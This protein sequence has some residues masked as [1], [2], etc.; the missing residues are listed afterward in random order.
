V[1]PE[2]L[3]RVLAS[4]RVR[5]WVPECG[6]GEPVYALAMRFAAGSGAIPLRCVLFGTARERSLIA[7]AR[8]AVYPAV[9][10]EARAPL[11]W[12]QHFFLKVDDQCHVRG[13]IRAACAFGCLDLACDPPLSRLHLIDASGVVAGSDCETW[14]WLCKSFHFAL[15]PDGLLLLGPRQEAVQLPGFE[16]LDTASGLYRRAPQGPRSWLP[17]SVSSLPP[18]MKHGQDPEPHTPTAAAMFAQSSRL[19]HAT[20]GRS[21]SHAAATGLEAIEA[22]TLVVTTLGVGLV[23]FD[24]LRR[25]RTVNRV[26][27]D[28]FEVDASDVVQKPMDR[29]FPEAWGPALEEMQVALVSSRSTH[30]ERRPSTARGARQRLT[31]EC[32][33]G[34]LRSF[35]VEARCIDDSPLVLLVFEETT[36]PGRA[37]RDDAENEAVVQRRAVDGAA[38]L[39]PREGE[40]LGLIAEGGSTKSIAERLGI[41]PSTVETYRRQIMDK[42][43]L[44]TIAELTKYAVRAGLT[45]P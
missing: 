35:W 36:N 21:S 30:G 6:S 2:L 33:D 29:V 31:R 9:A 23:I 43:E 39:S 26:F 3:G 32:S 25:V 4:D 38:P 15:R 5:I 44:R 24:E 17:S 40:V 13:D 19:F 42:L 8:A 27:C 20:R 16:L 7:A 1:I 18:R 37:G 12:Q 28:T 10:I 22:A 34:T 14:E 11:A 41:A 45:T